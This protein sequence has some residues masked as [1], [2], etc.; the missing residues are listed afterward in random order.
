[1][2]ISKLPVNFTNDDVDEYK[3]KLTNVGDN[4]YL[5]ED[6]S[7]Y[8]SKG[9]YFGAIQENKIN[10]TVNQVIDLAEQNSQDVKDIMLGNRNL[11][12]L[13][14]DSATTATTATT[15]DRANTTDTIP[16]VT[17][18]GETFDGS[19]DITISDDTK[20]AI[21]DSFMLTSKSVLHFSNNVC[22][23]NNPNIT[24]NSLANVVFTPSCLEVA[25]KAGISVE[26]QSGKLV[27]TAGRTPSSALTASIYIRS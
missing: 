2:A 12:A 18:N 10:R 25:K 9:S 4:D 24:A 7:D 3:Y 22:T 20:L 23:I 21:S 17:I 1:M 16:S 6:V 8:E 5:V 13:T 27:I 19:E 26:T 15:A 11:S 14:A